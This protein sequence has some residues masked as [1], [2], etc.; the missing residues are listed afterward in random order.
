MHH[1][2]GRSMGKP[3]ALSRRADHGTG[4]GDNDNMVLLR[5]EL[6]AIRALEGIALE[7]EE[8]EILREIRKG[9]RE[10]HQEDSVAIA[11]RDLRKGKGKSLRSA[12]WSESDGLLLF[13]GKIYVPNDPEIRRRIVSLHHD[14]LIAGHAG[15]WKT[16]EL[17]ARNYWWPQ[18]S[19]YIGQ[20]V[21]TCDLCMRT[22]VQRHAPIGELH[23]LPIPEDRWSTL[24]VDFI[25]E[26]PESNGHDAVMVVVDSVTK[27]AHFI[28]T[29]TT[30]SALGSAR[31]YLRNVWKLHGLPDKMLSDRGPQFIAEFTRELYRLLGIKLATSTAYHP[32]TDG[33]TE[34]VNQELEQY[35]RLFVNERQNDWDD[36]LP[37][38]EFQ[39]NN[40]VHSSTQ[41]TP[42]MLDTGR[43]P[44]MG[45]EPHQPPS[46]LESVAE[47]QQRMADSLS[48]ARSALTK[49][50]DDM[51]RYYNQRRSPAP[52]FKPGDRVF[53]DASDISTTRPSRKLSHRNLGPFVVERQVSPIAYRLRL[54]HSM[55]RLH[56]VFNVV[57]LTPAP[58]DPIPG[59]RAQPPPPPVIVSGEE[60]YVVERIL[61]SRLR[62]GKLQFKVKWKGY[63][64]EEN[65]WEAASDVHAEALV[66]DFYRS[67]PG[68]PRFIA[69][70]SFANL[71][72]N[73]RARDVAP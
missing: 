52:T 7:G 48:E 70:A 25:V 68:A 8:H 12:E 23:P 66:K 15:R 30:V 49:A 55:S 14:T 10:G 57:K 32:Q 51:A 72:Q 59:R 35:I 69:S 53:L 13:R 44:H 50:K 2:P 34:R 63:G 27:R 29:N 62:R 46:R 45:F 42:F 67:N 28:P 39:Y 33:Q 3:D 36:L 31:L 5:P 71:S 47:F 16:L 24:S 37:L 58:V 56:P 21:R 19:R 17:V 4:S 41:Q 60:E 65:S 9:N 20:Y 38:A 64:A 11:A 22:K 61:D 54:P 6:F 18:M 26:L 73:W 43:N 40:H 1:R